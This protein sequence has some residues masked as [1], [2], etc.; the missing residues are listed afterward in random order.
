MQ[1]HTLNN[2]GFSLVELII[3]ITIMA[4]LTGALAPF[5]IRYV[6]KSRRSTDVQN[7][8]TLATAV[9]CAINDA[10]AYSELMGKADPN[11][12]VTF[13]L[14]SASDRILPADSVGSH[15]DSTVHENISGGFQAMAIK[16]K[17]DANGHAITATDFTVEINTAD[18]GIKVFIGNL[19]CYP[20]NDAMN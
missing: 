12:V 8:N 7:A 19:E 10:D 15:F 6:A 11:S 2:H 14:D 13:T 17:K 18:N 16:S 1:K 9:S 4:I 5:L 3:V 20:N